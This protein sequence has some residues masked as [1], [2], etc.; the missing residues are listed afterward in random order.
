MSNIN[1]IKTE[2]IYASDG[3]ATAKDTFTSE[4]T[5]NNSGGMATQAYLPNDFWQPKGASSAASRTIRVVA[6]G[7]AS[8]TGTPSFTFTL[9]GGS[10]GSTT[11]PI[12]LGSAALATAT[13]ISSVLWTFEGDI[14]LETIGAPGANSTIRGVGTFTADGYSAATTTRV[15]PLFGGAASPGTAT[16]FD[17]TIANYLNFNV[18]CTASSGSN[19][20]T[21][22]QFLVYGLN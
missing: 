9:R 16:T 2:L 4:V 7:L 21:L 15:L 1:P 19:S 14:T 3:A 22:L 6:R 12:L 17:A 10:A 11:A 5:I 20:I 18:T 8:S 13:G